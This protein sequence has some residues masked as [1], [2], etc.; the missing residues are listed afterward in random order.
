[1]KKWLQ[2]SVHPAAIMFCPANF[3]VCNNIIRML[4]VVVRMLVVFSYCS[5]ATSIYI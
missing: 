5:T 3:S 2:R 4:A 1:M